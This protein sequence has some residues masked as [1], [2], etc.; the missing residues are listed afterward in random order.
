M[1][2]VHLHNHTEYSL[3]DGATKVE[4]MARRAA[5][6][7]MPAIAITDHGYMYGVPAFSN[8][9]AKAGIKPIIGCE[10]YF[11]PDSELRRDRKPELYHMILLAKN[12]QGYHNLVKIVSSA[13]V[14]GFY[15]KPRVTFES[16][17]QHADGLIAT[18]A[19][20]LG[21]VPKMLL[22]NQREDALLWAERFAG[23]FAPGDFYIEMQDQG[24]QLREGVSQHQLNVQLNE[25]AQELG[26]KTVAANDMHYL[27]QEDSAMQDI[28]LC[29]GTG[30]K[31]DDT[32]RMR[33]SNDQFY[34]KSEQEMREALKHFPEACSTTLEIAEKCEVKLSRDI[35]LPSIPLPEGENNESMLRKETEAGLKKL[36]GEPLPP[37]VVERFEQE[38]KV[39]CDK[40]F[41]AYFLVVQ[42]FTRWA[43]QNGVGVGPGRGSAAGSIISYALG[44]TSLDPLENG[45]LFER[46]LSPERTEMPDIDIDFDE[47]G[48]FKVI[49]HLRELYGTEKVAHVITFGKMK[50][51][52]AVVD[53]T[54]VFDYPIFIGANI[55][56]K[57]PFGPG[58]T[59]KGALGIHES[60]KKN[61]DRNPDLI[62]E[63]RE[64]ADAK[65]I[66]DA[67]LSLEDTIRGEGI[68]ASAVIICRDPVDD[69]VPVKYDT[70]GGVI[71][72]QYDGTHNAELGLLKMDFLGLRTLNVLQKACEYVKR[73]HGVDIDLD[74]IPF[75]D[76]KVFDLLVRGSTA[77]VFQVESSGMTALIRQMRVDRYS[78]IVAAIALF[79]PGPLNSGMVDDF[80]ARKA[81]KR[82]ISYYDDRLKEVLEETYGAIVYQE[83]VMRISMRMSG[84]TAGESDRIRKAMAKKDIDLMT[85][86]PMDWADGTH[87]T[88]K[89]HWLGGAERN[90]FRRDLAQSIWD[91]VEKFAEYAFNK[92]HSA[93]YAI[94]VMQTAW[95]KAYYPTEYMA[96][97]LSSFVGKADRLI[98]YI[99]ACKQGGIDVLPPD[100]NSSG[101]EFT[102]LK[103]GIRFGLAGI[104]GVGEGAADQIRAER[105]RNGPFTSLH[106]FVFRIN[107]TLCNK[108]TVESLIKA[109][110]FDSTG[111][112][113]RQMMRFLEED[114]LME[115]AA[116]RHRDKADGQVSLFD[117][118]EESGVDSGFEEAIPEPDGV[119]WERRTKLGFEREI[120]KIYVS[121]HPLSPY[122]EVLRKNSDYSLSVFARSDDDEDMGGDE[123]DEELGPE[124]V[125][126]NKVISLAGMVS[127][128]TPMVSKK[129]ERMAKFTLED[130]EGSI[131]AIIFPRYFAESGR[132]LETDEDGHDAIVRVRCRYEST[133]RGQQILVNEVKRL[134]MSELQEAPAAPR[135]LELHVRSERFN[136]QVSDGLSRALRN[137]PGVAPVI[138]FLAQSDGRKLRAELPTTVDAASP[139]LRAELEELLGSGCLKV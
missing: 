122:A 75:D 91:D 60:E 115:V 76:P 127:N 42:E 112:T 13:A 125:P 117:M 23:I 128:L 132:A 78:D 14:D 139:R 52:Q 105:E 113:R 12:P 65:K 16:L 136:Q 82:K 69:H 30:S 130:M 22:N 134:D 104:R 41:P 48:R 89:E 17:Q 68:H 111:Y 77:G 57:I 93:A 1:G 7:E 47:D 62:Q 116:K 103:E 138:L 66:I 72:T 123:G 44:I 33:F 71:I 45:L 3:L 63:Y 97:V 40:G 24:M 5:E 86:K 81:G 137:C 50:A 99:A 55:S 120:L 73:N 67:A 39:I 131:D 18:S 121:D 70:K 102:P 19:C 85:K 98:Q 84:F 64:N 129:G 110:A 20:L 34:M 114:N 106:D 135:A 53:A 6:F 31:F 10:I 96:A 32:D 27:R 2:F 56:K 21:I 38:Y 37:E 46:F 87:E 94:L 15:Y 109:G 79:R 29:I 107:N 51:K 101:R 28:M 59:L 49:E 11:T 126:Q 4:A 80:V 36:Y 54:R 133:D 25:L 43:K 90:G 119:E 26:L 88:M 9:C 92:S 95:I 118:F 61:A 58:A 74:A 35:I 108:R 124:K 8:A 83:Q 100:V